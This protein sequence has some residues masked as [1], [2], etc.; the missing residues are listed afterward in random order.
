MRQTVGSL[1]FSV[2]MLCGSHPCSR[3]LHSGL[4]YSPFRHPQS[5]LPS[6]RQY[7]ANITAEHS[8]FPGVSQGNPKSSEQN[9]D[10]ALSSQ[11]RIGTSNQPE[12]SI[13]DTKT[14]NKDLIADL[15]PLPDFALLGVRK[16]VRVALHEAFPNIRTPTACQT[17]FIPAILE[18]KVVILKDRTG[19]GK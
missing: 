7:A 1:A 4:F 14:Q 18:R 10:V 9:G 8:K 15:E 2:H 6:I 11:I 16:S 13:N 3:V 17:E 5:Y 12:K 19:T